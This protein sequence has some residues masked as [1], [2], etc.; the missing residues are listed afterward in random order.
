[1]DQTINPR[2][3]I[4]SPNKKNRLTET[5]LVVV[6]I[7]VCIVLGLFYFDILPIPLKLPG[8]TNKPTPAPKP[9]A[10]QYDSAKAKILLTQYAKDTLKPEFIP[11]DVEV[12]QGLGINNKI[13]DFK[14]EFKSKFTTKRDSLSAL[15]RYLEKTN[16]PD[17]Y[18][19]YVQPLSVIQATPTAMLANALLTHYFINPH[20][21]SDCQTEG[22]LSYCENFQTTTEGKRGYGALFLNT[23][24]TTATLTHCF[25]SK[26]N[27]DYESL[28]S[29]M[30]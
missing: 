26:E 23:G 2:Q 9:T 3:G 24:N 19:I 29:C 21:V 7:I 16:I 15:F 6:I 1:M 12:K 14:Y 8:Q 30:R 25:V 18:V 27:K 4:E 10:F 20:S 5:I 11:A 13:R 17:T 22:V 28:K